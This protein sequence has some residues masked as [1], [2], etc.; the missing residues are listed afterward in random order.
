MHKVKILD[1]LDKELLILYTLKMQEKD[2]LNAQKRKKT[3]ATFTRKKC[4][5]NKIM[6]KGRN[7]HKHF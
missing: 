6:R 2:K 5:C 4:L 3:H 7:F 1:I